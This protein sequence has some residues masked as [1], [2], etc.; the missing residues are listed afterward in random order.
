MLG[1]QD[2]EESS[3]GDEDDCRP[4]EL[5]RRADRVFA[6]FKAKGLHKDRHGNLTVDLKRAIEEVRNKYVQDVAMAFYTAVEG[7]E[8][9]P[10]AEPA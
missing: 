5:R 3:S 10:R 7:G 8:D 2:R 9:P 4:P 1:P 6:A